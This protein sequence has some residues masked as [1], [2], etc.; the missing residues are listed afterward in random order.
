MT[1]PPAAL[2]TNRT[3][4]TPQQD[5]HPA[6]H[7]AIAQA[8]NDTVATVQA[9]Q[10]LGYKGNAYSAA[11]HPGI[12]QAQVNLNAMRVDW[13]VDAGHWYLVI[14]TCTYNVDAG[15]IIVQRNVASNGTFGISQ[16]QIVPNGWGT[17]SNIGLYTSGSSGPNYIQVTAQV[18]GGFATANER[19]L[20]IFDLT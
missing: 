14:S 16:L 11:Q 20:M 6:D 18:S 2:P 19:S 13:V 17:I 4:A 10:G 7:N 5:T 9:L 15:G 1:W 8:I 3:N 12:A